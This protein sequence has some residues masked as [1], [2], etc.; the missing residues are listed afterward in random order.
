M[1]KLHNIDTIIF[2]L[3]NLKAAY[4]AVGFGGKGGGIDSESSVR[5]GMVVSCT[6]S[7][8]SSSRGNVSLVHTV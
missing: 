2:K 8:S 3:H 1:F 4:V 5:A 6:T 7:A